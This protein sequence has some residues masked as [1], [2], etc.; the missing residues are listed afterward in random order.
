M[1][2]KRIVLLRRDSERLGTLLLE[3]TDVP[4][5]IIQLLD[6]KLSR[7]KLVESLDEAVNVVTM[8]SL[9]VVRRPPQSR[10]RE[11][12]LVYPDDAAPA[13]GSVSVLSPL[14]VCV[15]GHLE[16]ELCDVG[17]MQFLDGTMVESVNRAPLARAGG[18]S[19]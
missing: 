12:R 15:L 8:D 6:D 19:R 4:A 11:L 16:G 1:K 10:V 17:D 7:A 18:D 3:H 5:A 14:G 9:V 2:L 13:Q